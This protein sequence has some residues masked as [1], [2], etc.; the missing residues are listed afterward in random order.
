MEKGD[1]FLDHSVHT[2]LS[3]QSVFIVHWHDAIVADTVLLLSRVYILSYERVV[4]AYVAVYI[5][6]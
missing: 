6:I 5:D 4:C 1:S 3:C 2:V